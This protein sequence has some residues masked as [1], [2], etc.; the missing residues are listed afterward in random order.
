MIFSQIGRTSTTHNINNFQHP[1]LTNEEQMIGCRLG[2][3]TWADTSCSGK[4]AYVESFVEG[5]TVNATGFTS[6]LGTMKNLPI[7]NVVYAYDTHQG[8]TILIENYNTIYL[9]KEMCDSLLNPI[10]AEENDV[11]VDT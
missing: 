9:G 6:S 4:H 2:V 8:E 7:A 1:I 11:R 5:R 3:D 10:Q